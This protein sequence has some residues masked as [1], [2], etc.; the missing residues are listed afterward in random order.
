MKSLILLMA[1]G[2]AF[3][4]AGVLVPAGHDQ[5][6]PAIFS[7]N[8][9][10]VEIRI[11]N[12]IAR[13]EVRQ[14]FANHSGSI[15]E[16]SWTFA[17]PARATVSDFAVWDDVVRIPGVIL[18]RKR[19]EDIYSRVRAMA[20]DPGLLTFSRKGW[21]NL[22]TVLA[23]LFRRTKSILPLL[24]EWTEL[25]TPREAAGA[26]TPPRRLRC[27]WPMTTSFSLSAR[28][29]YLL[30]RR[31]PARAPKNFLPPTLH[32]APIRDSICTRRGSARRQRHRP[33]GV[34]VVAGPMKD[35]ASR[36]IWS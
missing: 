19:A 6:D 15:Q 29:K 17:L 32:F 8:E 9:M 1:A 30:P 27:R 20:I 13:V 18:E 35:R 2:L 33:A 31:S 7:L 25:S 36:A 22:P 11:D 10:T 23:S 21:L 12:G 14:I 3:G 16:G 26:V 34:A 4:D 5:P 24:S 28:G